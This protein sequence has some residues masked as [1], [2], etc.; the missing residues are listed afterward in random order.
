M[1]KLAM[2]VA[3]LFLASSLAVA[4]DSAKTVATTLPKAPLGARVFIVS[5]NDGAVVGPEVHVKFGV[6]GIKLAP[7]T[8]TAANT[9]HHHLLIDAATLPSMD[10]P[11]PGDATHLHFGK[12]QTETSIHLSPGDHTLQLDFGNFAHMQFDP[13]IVSKKITVH[14][15]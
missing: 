7:A 2:F 11:I 8:E 6:K 15:K 1:R 14:V 3:G 10:A 9:G 4:Q 13:P 5:P 12:A